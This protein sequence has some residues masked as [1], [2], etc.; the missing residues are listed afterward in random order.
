MIELLRPLAE[1]KISVMTF[2]ISQADTVDVTG[3]CPRRYADTGLDG[4]LPNKS[5]ALLMFPKVFPSG[6]KMAPGVSS[7]GHFT[8]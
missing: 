1:P 8:W 2:D 3:R 4:L 5:L 7:G 6:M